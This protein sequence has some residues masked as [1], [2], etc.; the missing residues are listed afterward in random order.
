MKFIEFD[1]NEVC[2]YIAMWRD[3]EGYSDINLFLDKGYLDLAIRT[4]V[5][6]GSIDSE[7]C[8]DEAKPME[9]F[10][11]GMDKEYANYASDLDECL[12][13]VEIWVNDSNEHYFI[14][15]SMYFVTD[16]ELTK[17][18]FKKQVLSNTETKRMFAL[19]KELQLLAHKHGY[20]VFRD[21]LTQSCYYAMEDTSDFDD[22]RLTQRYQY[23]GNGIA[24]LAI[25]E[26]EFD[27]NGDREEE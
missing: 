13:G 7:R 21:A 20:E 22:K 23:L 2:Q 10:I 17:W 19:A 6:A 14:D 4:L 26:P 18:G 24:D 16:E 8:Y 27:F 25:N 15:K 9:S 1:E 12:E 11:E 3:S 5:N